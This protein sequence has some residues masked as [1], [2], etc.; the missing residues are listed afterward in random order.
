MCAQLPQGLRV[1]KGL[2]MALL[3]LPLEVGKGR[4]SLWALVSGRFTP[5]A[6]PEEDLALWLRP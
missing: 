4:A 6:A 1:G 3:G 5:F 2:T